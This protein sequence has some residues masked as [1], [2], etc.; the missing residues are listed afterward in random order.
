LRSYIDDPREIGRESTP[1]LHI[2][3]LLDVF[4]EVHRVMRDDG[5]MFVNYGD[6]YASDPAKGASGKGKE[7]KYLGGRDATEQ[8]R[9]PLGGYKPKDLLSM[10]FRVAEALRED[11]WYHRST[12]IWSKK[13]PMPESVRGSRWERCR[14]RVS[15]VRDDERTI[16]SGWNTSRD[17]AHDTVDGRYS[18]EKDNTARTRWKDCPGC[19]KCLDNGG[20][21][22]RMNAGRP[23]T[24]HEYVFMFSKSP[25]YFYNQDGNR[26]GLKANSP[27]WGEA[28]SNKPGYSGN[29]NVHGEVGH[30][31]PSNPAGR[32]LWTVWNDIK[33]SSYKGAHFAVM[34]MD[35]AVR[36]V[37][38]GTSEYGCCPECGNQ[39]AP[40][41]DT[42]RVATRPAKDNKRVG[43]EAGNT[44][45]E[46]H[47]TLTS[48][49][50]W[51][52][53]CK[54]SVM[55]SEGK[56]VVLDPFHGSGTTGE[57][58]RECGCAYIGCELNEEYIKLGNKRFE[59]S[60]LF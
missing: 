4:G 33:Q 50:D 59:Q 29:P 19:D 39:Y 38:L 10:P 11:G 16:P 3:N 14:V 45:P 57:A 32:N 40:V 28:E 17:E 26:V 23:T 58:A 55:E 5:V 44:D 21:I 54:C 46:R 35:L 7:S 52:P 2:E 6:A 12:I 36:C 47:E 30:S 13:S 8:T 31:L 41:V 27:I 53:T 18:H 56:P 25:S 34:P 42:E 49:F 60:V 1:D 43:V 15:G 22:Y 48:V 37:K 24:S 9:R 20:Y 51:W